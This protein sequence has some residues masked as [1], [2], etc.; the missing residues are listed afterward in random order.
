[1][2]YFQNMKHIALVWATALFCPPFLAQ[3]APFQIY[4]A[5]QMLEHRESFQLAQTSAFVD[6]FE[7]PALIAIGGFDGTAVTASVEIGVEGWDA[8][9]PQ[10]WEMTSSMGQARM[11]F[12]AEKQNPFIWVFG[13]FDG[14][15][16]LASTESFDPM[17]ELWTQGPDMLSPRTN[18][19]SVRL[20]D[21]RILLTGGYD[22]Q[23][24]TASCEFFDPF[25]GTFAEAPSMNEGRA[26]HTITAL[27]DGRVLVTGGYN[28]QAGFQLASCELFDP[29]ESTWTEIAPLPVAVDNHAATWVELSS[30]LPNT[31]LVTGWRVFNSGLN[32]FEGL[33]AGAMLD[34]T[35]MTWTAFDLNGPHSYHLS[36]HL[37]DASPELFVLGGADQTGAG[38][39]TTYGTSEWILGPEAQPWPGLSNQTANRQR[40]AGSPSGTAMVECYTVCGGSSDLSG[41]CFILCPE[42]SG[43]TER[44]S[45]K[46]Q[47]GVYPNPVLGQTVV[48]STDGAHHQGWT[49]RDVQGREVLV[50]Q[51]SKMNVHGVAPGTFLLEVPGNLPVR[52]VVR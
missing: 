4:G 44:P 22:G 23:E 43:V 7:Q 16:T 39:E 51:G 2:G 29:A 35:T 19:R 24:E 46:R 5:G 34:L 49:L 25:T 47:V 26:S 28:A 21:G 32:L 27:D 52:V 6:G 50:G 40:A 45:Q 15:F 12:Q 17:T 1:M 20:D 14:E 10:Y 30:S 33:S 48:W 11:D 38:V 18:H 31:V 9:G 36:C 41:S 13:G 8:N 42:S 37:D 3:T